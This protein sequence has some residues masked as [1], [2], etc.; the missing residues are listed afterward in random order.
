MTD[1]FPATHGP[2][3]QTPIQR[4]HAR[5][6]TVGVIGLRYVGLPLVCRF[7]EGFR[8]IGFDS[9]DFDAIAT[10]ARLVFDARGRYA[11]TG[12][13]NQGVSA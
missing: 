1:R 5:D 13:N 2:Y 6:A 10:Y 4:C 12:P 11:R 3:G 9:Q 8:T 7:A